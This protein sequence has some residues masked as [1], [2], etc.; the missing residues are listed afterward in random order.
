MA[1]AREYMLPGPIKC[2]TRGVS[3]KTTER[4]K[5]SLRRMQKEAGMFVIRVGNDLHTSNGD[6]PHMGHHFDRVGS[7]PSADNDD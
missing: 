7:L 5:C 4:E 1:R 3:A 2:G 6:V